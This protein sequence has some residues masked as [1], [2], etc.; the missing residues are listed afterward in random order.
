MNRYFAVG[1]L[2]YGSLSHSQVEEDPEGDL[3]KVEELVP[4]L[5][6]ILSS[7]RDSGRDSDVLYYLH[8]FIEE[9]KK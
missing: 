4:K 2:G 3:V 7:G 8:I 5:E 6:T 9:L 1:K